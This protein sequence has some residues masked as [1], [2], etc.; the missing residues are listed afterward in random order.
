MSKIYVSCDHINIS[1][2]GF[3]NHPGCTFEEFHLRTSL[4][5]LFGFHKKDRKIRSDWYLQYQNYTDIH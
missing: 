3:L 1:L 4:R 5:L 2:T